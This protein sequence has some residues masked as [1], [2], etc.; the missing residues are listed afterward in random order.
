MLNWSAPPFYAGNVVGYQINYTTPTGNPLIKITNDTGTSTSVYQV[1]SLSY[2][3]TYSFRVG[4]FSPQSFNMTGNILNVTTGQ[5]YSITNHTVGTFDVDA[6]NPDVL[7]PFKFQRTDDSTAGTTTLDITFPSHYDMTCNLDSKFAQTS[8]N[9][10]GLTSSAAIVSGDEKKSSFVFTG[11]DNEI[12]TVKCWDE[13]TKTEQTFLL[14]QNS[15]PLLTQFAALRAG[16]YGTAGNFGAVDLIVLGA[17]IFSMVGFNRTTPIAGIIL[18]VMMIG[19]LS[20]FEIITWP[21]VF[22]GAIAVIV[23]IALVRTRQR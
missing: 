20:Y 1:G 22:A 6:I 7:N 23:M 16:D 3:T 9:Y 5:D 2:N 12:V 18:S 8:Q 15:F 11:L 14:T 21:T 4:V 13:I 17:V 19:A 10:T